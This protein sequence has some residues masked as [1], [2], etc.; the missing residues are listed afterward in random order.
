MLFNKG[1]IDFTFLIFNIKLYKIK[2]LK[3]YTSDLD[4]NLREN[5]NDS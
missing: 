2:N 3:L 4:I 1:L 5:Q